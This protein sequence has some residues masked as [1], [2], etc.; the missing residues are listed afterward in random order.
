MDRRTDERN[1]DSICALTAHML[2]RAKKLIT[3]IFLTSQ[4]TL[5]HPPRCRTEVAESLSLSLSLSV[6]ATRAADATG[7]AD[8]AKTL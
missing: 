7:T 3:S 2:S 5:F 1:C 6:S 8:E 4:N